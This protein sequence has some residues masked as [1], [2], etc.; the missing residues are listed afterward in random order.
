MART[1]ELAGPNSADN[2]T[3]VP[4]GYAPC[5][6]LAPVSGI[7]GVRFTVATSGGG[8][9]TGSVGTLHVGNATV[10]AWEVQVRATA[11]TTTDTNGRVFTYSY[12]AFTGGNS[13]PVFHT[14]FYAT[15][16]GQRYQQTMQGFDPN[17]YA[18]WSNT[19]GF[20][21]NGQPLYKD[22]RGGGAQVT[23][24]T[25]LFVA[26]LSAQ[27]PQF[28]IFFST[29]DPTGPNAAEATTVLTALGIPLSPASPTVS[30]PT[31][32]GQQSG[33]Q[34]YVGGGG[35]FTFTASNDTSYQ[36]VI[37]A[38]GVDFD[39]AK[40]G[41]A[42]LTG[43]AP[44]GNNVV[45]WNGNANNG[46]PFPIGTF[47]FQIIGRNGEIHFPIIDDEGNVNGGPTLTKLNGTPTGDHTV[48]FDDRGY[49]TSGGTNVGTLNGLLCPASPPVPPTPDH[50]LLGID[51]SAQTLSGPNCNGGTGTCYYRYWPAIGNA[52][53]DCAATAGFGD[54]K[55]LDLWAFQQSP[56]QSRTLVINAVNITLAKSAPVTAPLNTPFDYT[57]DLGN[58]GT[59]AS[60]MTLT[61]ADAL[62]AGVVANSV[63]AG[64]G[65]S[66]VNCGPLPSA[67]G[68][69]L[70]CTVNLSAPLPANAPNGAAAFTI[71]AT[72]SVTGS[73]T[74][75]A[76]VDPTGS[77]NPPPPGAGCA[78]A[79]SCGSAT[80]TVLAPPAI[81][82]AFGVSTM[83]LGGTTSLTFTITN[84]NPANPLNGVA[85]TDNLPAGLAVAAVPN[86]SNTCGGTFA[87]GAGATTL[88]LSGATLASNGSC[89]LAV[90]VT[91]TTA[92]T[93]NNTTG[94]VSSTD[95]GVGNSASASI[96]VLA[97]PGVT[98]AFNPTT[99]A[100]NGTSLLGIT[101]SNPD[102]IDITGVA[103][104]D[105]LPA[106]LVT[107]AASA[108]T[109]CTPGTAAQ[110]AS[111]V[112]LSGGTIPANGSCTVSVTV[113]AAS[114]G[115]YVN[116]IPA[117]AVT[118]TNAG[119]NPNPTTDTLTVIAPPVIGKVFGASSVPLN[120]TT[121]LTFTITN[122]AAN[123]VALSGVAFSDPLPSGLVVATPNGLAGSCGGGTITATAGSG[124]VTLSGATLAASG[125]CNFSVN[126][127]GT[128]A[129]TQT[130]TTGNV[131]S[132]NGGTGNT[133]TASVIVVAPPSIAKSFAPTAIA[134]SGVSTLTLTL[135]NPAANTVAL[136]GVAV[137][138]GLPAG[139]TVASP[140]GLNNTCGGTA[141]ATSG[142]A[143]V[144]LSG[145]TLAVNGTCAL[146]L[147]VTAAT[148]GSY[149]NTT[150]AVSSTN[151]GTGNTATATLT[152]NT[153][154]QLSVSKTAT[155]N[156]FVVGQPAS[157]TI[158]V[159]NT[160]GSPTNANITLSDNLPVGITL[161]GTSGTGWACTGTSALSCTYSGA[162]L[163]PSA[164]ATLTLNVD[165]GASATNGNN[166]ATASGGGDPTCPAANNCVGTVIVPVTTQAA[167]LQIVKTG[168]ATATAGGTVSYTITVTNTGP[169]SAT[170]ATVSDPAPSGLTFVSAGAPCSGGF[171][172]NLG[173]LTAGQ[174]VQIPSVVFAVAPSFSGTVVNIASVS[175][176]QPDPTPNNNSSSVSTTV[177]GVAAPVA[178]T[179]IN[180]LW[181]MLLLLGGLLGAGIIRLNCFC[182][183]RRRRP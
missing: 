176:D 134:P 73:L 87:P 97:P 27:S 108:T 31:F 55:G 109:T 150:S 163:A 128:A 105:N 147:A 20:L 104:T 175:A 138:D 131:T 77:T 146:S 11:T 23:P 116:T 79:T 30:N 58:T 61:V 57:I 169:N 60:G 88:T 144:S 117:G 140:N 40:P 59:G 24:G 80:V 47:T 123:T 13:R 111:T 5:A 121:S 106:G 183:D 74:N 179:P 22:I 149:V 157:Y 120:G 110:S 92:G 86:A 122:P 68:A 89:T 182:I 67:A 177:Q 100:P 83:P 152:V 26:E 158:T 161:T 28:P 63:S 94:A 148:S 41:N 6:Y 69:T 37:S 42:T 81:A 96:T 115:S 141:T 65:V 38:D 143:T 72:A 114:A 56:V 155:P 45:P 50:S 10:A 142:S 172:C 173:T 98:K 112:G 93:K 39:P 21:D 181:T 159:T 85:F 44:D 168:P 36:I 174:S 43:L 33:N 18:L 126:V 51:S 170:N 53:S 71:N 154:P 103:F 70:P 118:S 29:I 14:L 46:T 119:S 139:M 156:P 25:G 125:S 113:T 7:Y 180:A 35:T 164:S 64:T 166:S 76:S 8:G 90:D 82:K 107:Q 162:A 62:P 34:T 165:V 19:S 101:L 151:G 129:G 49:V 178:P 127:A 99:I 1:N 54:A 130:N 137:T 171:P 9:P 52:N 135:V 84:P 153:G 17:G 95:G 16:D 12:V 160:G 124:T 32:N 145:G 4:N 48:Y 102:A 3:T 75:D 66:S 136:T 133:A 132:T 91:G 2:S 78:P 15:L 167:D